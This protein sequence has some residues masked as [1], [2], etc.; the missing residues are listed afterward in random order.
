MEL[1]ANR[2]VVRRDELLPCP[3]AKPDGQV[4][5]PDYVRE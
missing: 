1:S 3:V 5:G 4:S 2:C